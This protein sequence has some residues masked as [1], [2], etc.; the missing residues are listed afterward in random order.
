VE[1]ATMKTPVA[2]EIEVHETLPI[3]RLALVDCTFDVTFEAMRDRDQ[4]R[5]AWFA[6]LDEVD[7]FVDGLDSCFEEEIA[8]AD[9][10]SA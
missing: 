5:G 2:C 9:I 7:A 1:V 8:D 4:M 10:L 3:R 6:S